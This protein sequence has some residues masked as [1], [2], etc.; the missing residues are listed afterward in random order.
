M[1]R[2]EADLQAAI[3]KKLSYDETPDLV[4]ITPR[5]GY[6]LVGLCKQDGRMNVT[7]KLLQAVG[8]FFQTEK[9]NVVK[10]SHVTELGSC[11]TC[12]YRLEDSVEFE[13]YQ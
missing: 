4:R 1:T 10:D 6:L 11:E 12:D 5:G 9:V 3:E 8:E 13:V 7:F 2:Q